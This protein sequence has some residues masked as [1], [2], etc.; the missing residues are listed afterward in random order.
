M[1]VFAGGRRRRIRRGRREFAGR[2]SWLRHR[3][4]GRGAEAGVLTSDVAVR[5]IQAGVRFGRAEHL[6]R[7][8]GARTVRA[9]LS[10]AAGHLAFRHDADEPFQPRQKGDGRFVGGS[11]NVDPVYL[12]PCAIDAKKKKIGEHTPD[13]N[14][15]APSVFASLLGHREAGPYAKYFLEENLRFAEDFSSVVIGQKHARSTL[16]SATRRFSHSRKPLAYDLS[17]IPLSD[18]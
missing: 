6:G 14:K 13:T 12:E 10:S 4:R 8:F 17:E 15:R 1:L 11:G 2:R 3:R 16:S 18:D 9:R 5:V 7:L